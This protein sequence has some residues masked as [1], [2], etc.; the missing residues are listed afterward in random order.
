VHEVK[1]A[2]VKRDNEELEIRIAQCKRELCKITPDI[3]KRRE[4]IDKK[5]Q[6]MN[7]RK[8][9]KE[10]LGHQLVQT[11]SNHAKQAKIYQQNLAKL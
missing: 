5:L 11:Y 6:E 4:H 2:K 7:E 1:L 3:R 10:N 8:S 9:Y